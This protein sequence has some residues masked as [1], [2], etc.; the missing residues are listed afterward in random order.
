[1]KIGRGLAA[2]GVCAAVGLSACGVLRT[3]EA[4]VAEQRSAP[5]SAPTVQGVTKRLTVIDADKTVAV[6]VG[7]TFQVALVGVPTAGYLWKEAQTP[8][9]LE[10]SAETGGPTHT[11]QRQPGFTGGNHWEVFAFKTTRAGTGVLVLE[12]RRPWESDEPPT[13]TFRVTIQAQ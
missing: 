12:Q 9:F 10:R 13:D 2:V 6:K 1:M 5:I 3:K 8:D 4:G 7:E 11:A